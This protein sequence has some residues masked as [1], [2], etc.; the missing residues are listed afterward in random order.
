MSE[1]RSCLRIGEDAAGVV[2][3]VGGDNPRPD[4]CQD[5]QGTD[6]PAFQKSHARI[7]QTYSVGYPAQ[8]LSS[9]KGGTRSRTRINALAEWDKGKVPQG[10]TKRQVGTKSQFSPRRSWLP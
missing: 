10:Q 7:S 9:K 2:V 3:D 4:Y 6:F 5:H 1:W 8:C